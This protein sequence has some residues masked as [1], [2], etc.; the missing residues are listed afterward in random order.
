MQNSVEL[1]SADFGLKLSEKISHLKEDNLL[2][3]GKAYLVKLI[4]SVFTDYEVNRK[5]IGFYV[6]FD[7]WFKN[8]IK[9]NRILN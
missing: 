2:S 5:K 3:K 9:T 4:K 6:S 8:W 7:N 1:R